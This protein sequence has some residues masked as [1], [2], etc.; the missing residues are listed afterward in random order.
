MERVQE[1]IDKL[2]KQ[3]RLQEHPDRLLATVHQLEEVLLAMVRNEQAPAAKVAVVMPPKRRPP[4]ASTTGAVAVPVPPP[5]APAAEAP[6]EPPA[7]TPVIADEQPQL[8][9]VVPGPVTE[10]I[11]E[12]EPEAIIP[13]AVA[14]PAAVP[15]PVPVVEPEP[16][17]PA[18]PVKQP[19]REPYTLHKPPVTAYTPP[20]PPPAPPAP[21]PQP[22]APA[23]PVTPQPEPE[24]E[25]FH[26]HFDITDEAPTLTQQQFDPEPLP[27]ELH[28]VIGSRAE[29]LNDRL[30]KEQVEL[31]HKLKETP[32]KDLR[33][34]IGVN[35]KF[36]FV[37]ELFRGDEAMYDRSLKTINN[38]HILPE[39]EYWISRELKVKLGWDDRSGVVQ[40]FYQLVRRRFA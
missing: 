20:P 8:A 27:R 36:L 31:A 15:A 25:V 18:E 19:M 37:R 6:V 2:W 29:S 1:L 16:A 26:L 39:A 35:D 28:E 30:K 22:L 24:R 5:P 12:A 34:A 10:Q 14:A 7:P 32:I 11:P 13:T 40:S 4:A 23:E 33:K 38:F 21:E 9:A 3:H 17:P